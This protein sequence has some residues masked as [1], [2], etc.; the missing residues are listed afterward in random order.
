M[1]SSFTRQRDS[2]K[3]EP[4]G[5]VTPGG[6]RIHGGEQGFNFNVACGCK[7]SRDHS[8]D[9]MKKP[10]CPKRRRSARPKAKRIPTP[11]AVPFVGGLA[12]EYRRRSEADPVTPI[13]TRKPAPHVPGPLHQ[14]IL[15]TWGC[16]AGEVRS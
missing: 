10:S 1:S 16:L 5:V 7:P 4:P 11:V 14:Y 9:R 3:C 15:K 8:R 2:H 6:K 13:C 12:A